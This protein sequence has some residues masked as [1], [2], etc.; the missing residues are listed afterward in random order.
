MTDT[1][2]VGASVQYL[3]GAG[4][5]TAAIVTKDWGDGV[6]NLLLFH[7]G[8]DESVVMRRVSPDRWALPSLRRLSKRA[9]MKVHQA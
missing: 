3:D 4:Q 8:L 9:P 5:P 7:D 6:V 1:N 2:L